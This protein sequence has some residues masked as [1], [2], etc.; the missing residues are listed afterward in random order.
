M[1]RYITAVAAAIAMLAV[2]YFFISDITRKDV[3]AANAF[4]REVRVEPLKAGD[5]VVVPEKGA[6]SRI[7]NAVVADDGFAITERS[8]VYFNRAQ[9]IMAWSA[10]IA[11]NFG[12]VDDKKASETLRTN[13]PFIGSSSSLAVPEYTYANPTACECAMA[14]SLAR[15]DRVCGVSASLIETSEVMT[16][17]NGQITTRPVE[18]AVAVNLRRHVM[19]LSPEAFANCGEDYSD[20]ARITEQMLCTE[21]EDITFPFD[22]KLRK[23]LNL[24]DSEPLHVKVSARLD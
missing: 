16:L 6:M 5:I 8:E 12:L 21:K 14:R 3:I 4:T 11:A 22:V 19:R 10:G 9:R 23:R 13:I 7:C 1:F 24:I 18:R 2:G 20:K 15:G 17:E